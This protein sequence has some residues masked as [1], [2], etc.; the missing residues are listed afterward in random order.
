MEKLADICS[1]W[2]FAAAHSL[3]IVTANAPYENGQ[4]VDIEIL[5]GSERGNVYLSKKAGIQMVFLRPMI[6]SW[7]W[8]RRE[9]QL[10]L[11]VGHQRGDETGY[12]DT[13]E[14]RCRGLPTELSR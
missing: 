12:N 7:I 3:V 1:V 6:F 14:C 2:N 9:I 5:D 10:I 4:R 8:S 11:C 13:R